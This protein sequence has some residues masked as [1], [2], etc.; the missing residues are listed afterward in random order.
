MLPC[1]PSNMFKSKGMELEAR[2]LEVLQETGIKRGQSVLDFGCGYGAYT[3]PASKIVGEQG[4]VNALDKDREALE[5]RRK[6]NESND[7][8]V[9]TKG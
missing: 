4:R 5:E 3:I 2:L 9:R 6:Q 7:K 1:P 8:M